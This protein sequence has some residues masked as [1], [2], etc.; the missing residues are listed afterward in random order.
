[1]TPARGN[2]NGIS[3]FIKEKEKRGSYCARCFM[4]IKTAVRSAEREVKGDIARRRSTSS[5]AKGGKPGETAL[6][7][8]STMCRAQPLQR[9]SPMR[10]IKARLCIEKINMKFD[11]F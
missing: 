7:Q 4:H 6:R 1:M 5:E 8:R 2:A 10:L 11:F 9:K 3:E